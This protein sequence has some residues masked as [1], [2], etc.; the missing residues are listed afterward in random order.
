MLS[1]TPKF[2]SHAELKRE[3]PQPKPLPN[4]PKPDYFAAL[5]KVGK[6]IF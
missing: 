6:S 5:Y 4:A 1:N 2:Y 3:A